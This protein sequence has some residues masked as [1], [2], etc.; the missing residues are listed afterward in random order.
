MSGTTD[1]EARGRLIARLHP[2]GVGI[3][4]VPP[5][6]AGFL[7]PRRSD[8]Y[9]RGLVVSALGSEQFIARTAITGITR[10][11]P[12]NITIS[13]FDG[14]AVVSAFRRKRLIA[15]LASAGYEVR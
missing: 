6:N 4:G 1:D 13:W 3:S 14:D 9:E 8:I 10:T 12:F 5:I 7:F 11:W 2:A 15:T